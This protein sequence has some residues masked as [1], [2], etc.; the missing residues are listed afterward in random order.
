MKAS[1]HPGW[2]CIWSCDRI[3][4]PFESLASSNPWRPSFHLTEHSPIFT[5]VPQMISTRPNINSH[6]TR[7]VAW[8][9]APFPTPWTLTPQTPLP[10]TRTLY[11]VQEGATRSILVSHVAVAKKNP[12]C[13]VF[14][15]P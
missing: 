3:S 15:P 5:F 12:R 11:G 2:G 9:A 14:A 1:R 4:F 7:D 6:N 8:Q 10:S 13:H